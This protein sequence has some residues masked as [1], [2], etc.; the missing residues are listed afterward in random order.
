MNSKTSLGIEISQ[1]RIAFALLVRT[2]NLPKLVK[3]GW[4][5]TPKDCIV[6]GNITD[7]NNLGKCLRHMLRANRIPARQATVSLVAN[8]HL[9]QIIDLPLEMPVNLAAF[10]KSEIK[11]SAIL[12]GR[13]HQSDYCGLSSKSAE[14]G[15]RAIVSA[16]ENKKLFPLIRALNIAQIEPVSIEPSSIG[17]I[18]ALF[19][20]FVAAN[21]NYNVLFAKLSGTTI[22]MCVFRKGVLDFI[23]SRELPI[24]AGMGEYPEIFYNQIRAIKQYYDVEISSFKDEQWAAVVDINSEY[25][26]IEDISDYLDEQFEKV[27]ICSQSNIAQQTPV[28]SETSVKEASIGA[29][30]MALK[31]ISKS[32]MNVKFDLVP[33]SE[34][35]KKALRRWA[36]AAACFA[37]AAISAIALIHNMM[38]LRLVQANHVIA[39]TRSNLKIEL[40]ADLLRDEKDLDSQ[41]R[42]FIDSKDYIV[43][44]L[45]IQQVHDWP[46]IFDALTKLS[47]K[48]LCIMSMRQVGDNTLIISG[49]V[50]A[51]NSAHQLASKLN[52]SGLFDS[53][54]VSQMNMDQNYKGLI[55]YTID[56][57]MK[58]KTDEDADIKS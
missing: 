48:T 14:G 38:Y 46:A 31:P 3:A 1:D 35:E 16:V 13:A 21:Y 53:A 17:W 18:R 28:A 10:I 39:G 55:N 22:T 37:I 27:D 44:A 56:C 58:A 2:K 20:N 32:R 5:D 43:D 49:K 4:V 36:F 15:K 24:G 54:V 12:L 41:I 50:T 33:E 45:N 23:R 8:P 40:I 26:K 7:P 25:V 57:V 11:H 29:I 47:P 30:G 19:D 6:D 9:I 34:R 42:T 52:E 51:H